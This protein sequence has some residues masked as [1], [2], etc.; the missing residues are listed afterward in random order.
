MAVSSHGRESAGGG[1]CT[2][3]GSAA[4]ERRENASD[5]LVVQGERHVAGFGG[6]DHEVRHDLAVEVGAQ[7]DRNK[8]VADG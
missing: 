8:F 2:Y 1:G 3:L 6:G 7:A 5:F 4:F